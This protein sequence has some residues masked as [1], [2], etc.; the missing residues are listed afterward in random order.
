MA[1]PGVRLDFDDPAFPGALQ[2][3]GHLVTDA[4]GAR[5]ELGGLAQTMETMRGQ[6][7][8]RDARTQQML[9]G[10][11]H[12]V[13]NPLAGID[14]MLWVLR[15]DAQGEA[16]SVIDD[17][18]LASRHL[19]EAIEDLLKIRLIE[20][21]ELRLA[22]EQVTMRSIAEEAV[23]TLDGEARARGLAIEPAILL[24]D[25]PFAAVDAQTRAA[26]QREVVRLWAE[27][28]KTVL[29]ITHSVEEA[30]LLGDRVIAL[31][32]RPGRVKA[33]VAG[34]LARPRDPTSP[35]FND[36]RRAIEQL[37]AEAG[38]TPTES[39]RGA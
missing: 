1:D 17:A 9:A 28:R 20:Q 4:A 24:M 10:I 27:T 2:L 14:G 13:R 26:L 32:P 19:R 18:A 36:Y 38:A 8:E 39:A 34:A 12:E 6:L 15:Q 22:R 3:V 11:A 31:T 37:L 33:D 25:E 23:A 35:A 7:A 21:G 5:D 16:A 30:V 29:F